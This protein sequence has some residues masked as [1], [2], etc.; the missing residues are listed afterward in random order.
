MCGRGSCDCEAS[1]PPQ[2]SS[3]TGPVTPEQ[4]TIGI[5]QV[6]PDRADDARRT[7]QLR[8]S[9]GPAAVDAAGDGGEETRLP[10]DLGLLRQMG[11]AT[12]GDETR[13]ESDEIRELKALVDELQTQVQCAGRLA[14][15]AAGATVQEIQRRDTPCRGAGW[16]K[17]QRARGRADR[18]AATARRAE[19]DANAA[20]AA[21]GMRD[22]A[23]ELAA[24]RRKGQKKT[25]KIKGITT[26]I[27]RQKRTT[28]TKDTPAEER[29][30]AMTGRHQ[31]LQQGSERAN[32]TVGKYEMDEF[33]SKNTPWD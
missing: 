2:E 11:P 13:V 32:S 5:A 27:T 15:L 6:T 8:F 30:A 21:A 7:E 24:V 9:I 28:T 25:T 14:A 22:R 16:L 1:H 31:C 3:T 20:E 29:R 18:L 23:A 12:A 4:R 10:V 19:A 33:R 17:A 26:T